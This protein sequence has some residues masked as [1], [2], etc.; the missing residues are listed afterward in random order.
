MYFLKKRRSVFDEPVKPCVASDTS[1][2]VLRMELRRRI[3]AGQQCP[4]CP[5][6]E[7]CWTKVSRHVVTSRH[8]C[9]LAV[10]HCASA[11]VFL[12][13]CWRSTSAANCLKTCC[14]RYVN[15]HHA[16]ATMFQTPSKVSPLNRN[17]L[18]FWCIIKS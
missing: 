6:R 9:A 11:C 13:T 1:G 12:T 10:N 17:H 8:L 15:V 16:R 18:P 2:N 3:K 4:K 7:Q 14:S 5:N